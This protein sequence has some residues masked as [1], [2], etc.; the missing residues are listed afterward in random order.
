MLI[1]FPISYVGSIKFSNDLYVM[2]PESYAL[3]IP[4]VT[5]KPP[6]LF[7]DN[8]IGHSQDVQILNHVL[9]ETQNN[10][11]NLTLA[12]ILDSENKS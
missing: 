5:N 4:V 3:S 10:N 9:M 12:A 7:V 1:H 2:G 11:D 6:I 8:I